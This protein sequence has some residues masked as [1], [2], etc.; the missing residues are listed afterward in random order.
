MPKVS[1]IVPTFNRAAL[2]KETIASILVQSFPDFELIVVDNESTDETESVVHSFRDERIR[3]FRHPN[4]GIVA[5]TGTSA[6]QRRTES[7]W[8]S[9]MTMTSGCRQNLPASSKLSHRMWDWDW[10]APMR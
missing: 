7:I 6:W 1:V 9:A 4:G 3:Y 10:C 5:V 2:L 8:P